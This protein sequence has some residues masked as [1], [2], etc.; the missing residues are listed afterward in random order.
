MWFPFSIRMKSKSLLT[1]FFSVVLM[2]CLIWQCLAAEVIYMNDGTVL[3]GTVVE[4]TEEYIKVKTKVGLLKIDRS[5]IQRIEY[6]EV[7][8]PTKPSSHPTVT[9]AIDLGLATLYSTRAK[10]IAVGLGAGLL[11]GCGLLYAENYALGIPALLIE[12]GLPLAATQVKDPKQASNLYI[13]VGISKILFEIATVASISTYNQYLRWEMGIETISIDELQKMKCEKPFLGEKD[14]FLHLCI[15]GFPIFGPLIAGWGAAQSGCYE[16]TMLLVS[17]VVIDLLL[18]LAAPKESWVE[19]F[20]FSTPLIIIM[21]DAFNCQHN[22]KIG[23]I[24][25]V[26]EGKRKTRSHHFFFGFRPAGNGFIF[27]VSRTF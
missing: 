21:R 9:P 22:E 16:L 18:A 19:Y 12:A 17:K 13:F 27:Q 14:S 6:K 23:H 1:K 7:E 4:A 26:L 25:K 11:P 24:I 3:K 10:S 15:S 5:D 20:V 8:E 2:V